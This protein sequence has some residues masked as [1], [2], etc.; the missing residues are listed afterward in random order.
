MGWI[1]SVWLLCTRVAGGAA[2]EAAA[3]DPD[4]L[5]DRRIPLVQAAAL[6][7]R[8][9]QVGAPTPSLHPLHTLYIP[10]LHPLYT[11]YRPRRAQGPQDPLSAGRSPRVAGRPGG[12]LNPFL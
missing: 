5:R 2:L 12:S 9:A 10:P 1:R 8:D 7:W 3:A 4:A 11:P 6:E